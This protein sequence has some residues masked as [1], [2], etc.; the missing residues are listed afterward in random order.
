MVDFIVVYW[1]DI[2]VQVIVKKGCILVKCELLLC[3]ME[4]IDMCVMCLGVVEID[5]YFVEW[6]KVDLILVF[7]DFD[8][9]VDKVVVDF[10]V[11]YFKDCFV[12]LV[13]V[14]G[15]DNG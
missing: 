5:D 14:G 10:E 2:L 12:V 15:C 11:V 3:F 7:D 8:V 4:V 9:E 13:Y 6:C 1:C